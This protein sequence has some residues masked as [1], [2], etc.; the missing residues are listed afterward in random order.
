MSGKTSSVNIGNITGTYFIQ[1]IESD[2]IIQL[3]CLNGN[4]DNDAIVVIGYYEELQE[5]DMHQM[6]LLSRDITQQFIGSKIYNGQNLIDIIKEDINIVA[7]GKFYLIQATPKAIIKVAYKDGAWH[8]ALN[9][10][11]NN[12]ILIS[13][14]E[15]NNWDASA[16]YYDVNNDQYYC[17]QCSSE[18]LIGNEVSFDFVLNGDRTIL[19]SCENG[20]I[21]NRKDWSSISN[22]NTVLNLQIGD[23]VICN[24][25]YQCDYNTLSGGSVYDI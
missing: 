5:D 22:V 13:S 20:S 7:L 1:K 23:G 14:A 2:P 9:N 16:L 4:I 6:H 24:T 15:I 18:Y 10:S 19:A 25:V 17:G 3:K 11:Q 8:L 21:V 12:E